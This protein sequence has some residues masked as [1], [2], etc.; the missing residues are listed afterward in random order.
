MGSRGI[1]FEYPTCSRPAQE[2]GA[3]FAVPIRSYAR[4]RVDAVW[5]RPHA[6]AAC[7]GPLSCQTPQI[8]SEVSRRLARQTPYNQPT[9]RPAAALLHRHPAGLQHELVVFHMERDHAILADLATDE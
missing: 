1:A 7:A 2:R 9:R 4:E 3:R 6:Q 5:P 8:T